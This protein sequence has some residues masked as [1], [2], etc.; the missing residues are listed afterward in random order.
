VE[1][2]KIQLTSDYK[3]KSHPAWSPDGRMIAY[4]QNDDGA[5]LLRLSIAD[6]TATPLADE[7]DP[8]F[9]AKLS[10]DGSTIVYISRTQ[11]LW[12]YSLQDGSKRLLTP[13]YRYV[14][15]PIWSP[16]GR[17]VA[18]SY[19]N[20][21]KSGIAI[22][23][24][25]GGDGRIIAELDGGY[26]CSSFCPKGEKI[27][28]YSRRGGNYEIT[29]ID[30]NS[31]EL[32]QLTSPPY[33]KLFPAWSPDGTTIAYVAYEDSCSARNSTIWLLSLSSGQVRELT[34]FP[35][36]VTQ[37]LW[38]PDGASL[39]VLIPRGDAR[40]LFLFSLADAGTRLLADTRE[41]TPG[42]FPDGRHLL[43]LQ[44]MGTSTIRAVSIEDKQTRF[45]SDKKIDA[46]SNPIW[47]NDTEVAFLRRKAASSPYAGSR[48]DAIWKISTAGGGSVQLPMDSTSNKSN[49]ALSPDRTQLLF[50]N[51]YSE[52]YMQPIAGGPLTNLTSNTR[53]ELSQPAWSSDGKYVVC[54][55]S[56]GLK[57]FALVSDKLVERRSFPGYYSY[58]AWSS[59][60]TFGYPIAFRGEG[61]IYTVS[62][63]DSEPHFVVQNGSY[64]AWSPDGRRL[65]YIWNGDIFVSKVFSEVK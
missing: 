26:Y 18:F 10:P 58:P 55:H 53:E 13:N 59:D 30:V 54:Q 28:L 21:A 5:R 64:P 29:S 43:M 22:V 60:P 51:G 15:T 42:W 6:T 4:N 23:P 38:S 14:S 19:V 2:D 12:L 48:S 39:I 1:Q 35:D 3:W 47:L 45:I 32:Q 34:N 7:F 40:G 65:A 46:A 20:R 50:D 36:V 8:F 61:G 49:L 31:G 27:A 52:I 63:D 62:L 24:A 57:V 16:D 37:L 9:D 33:E 41:R 17:S 25:D 56:S 11:Y 44:T